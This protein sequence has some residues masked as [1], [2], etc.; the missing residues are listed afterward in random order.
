MVILIRTNKKKMIYQHFI[1]FWDGDKSNLNVFDD[2]I[3]ACF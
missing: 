2:P 1:E 3:K